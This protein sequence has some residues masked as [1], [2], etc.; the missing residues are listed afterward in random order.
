MTAAIEERT[1]PGRAP[2][3]PWV[4]VTLTFGAGVML[5]WAWFV[6]GFLGEPSAVGRIR[7]VLVTSSAYSVASA[8]VSLIGAIGLMRRERWAPT[9]AAIAS[10]SMTF[11]VVGAVFGIPA[12]IGLMS[13][14]RS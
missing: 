14:R 10:A 9:V 5:A 3:P 11:T 1:T 2:T 4:W 8:L 13:P 7:L 6:I 12:L